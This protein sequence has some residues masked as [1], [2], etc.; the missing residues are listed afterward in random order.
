MIREADRRRAIRIALGEARPGDIVLVLGK[1]HE[2]GQEFADGTI[3]FDDRVVVR[4]EA[5]V[6]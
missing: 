1:G 2:V 5:A 3:P 6:R 4:Q